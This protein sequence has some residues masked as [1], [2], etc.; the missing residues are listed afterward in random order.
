MASQPKPRLAS[1]IDQ[2]ARGVS[3][4]AAGYAARSLL[5]LGLTMM[6]ARGL[7]PADYGAISVFLALAA[8]IA[9][10]AGAWPFVAV[11]ILAARGVRV[12]AVFRPALVLA[13]IGAVVSAAIVLPFASP[14]GLE[15]SGSL[16]RLVLY[17]AALLA[18]HGLYSVFQTEGRMQMIAFT[19]AGER[20]VTLLLVASL[21]AF[22][23]LTVAGAEAA[24]AVA[25]AVFAAAA[26]TATS[27]RLRL[28]SRGGAGASPGIRVVVRTV[29]AMAVVTTAT[30]LIAW[31]DIVLL[32]A[33][34]T[35]R[36]TGLY[37]LAY[38]IFTVVIQVGAL[39]IVAALP[40]H[41]RRAASGELDI[42]EALPRGKLLA[43][44]RAWGAAVAIA[45]VVGAV[46]LTTVFGEG[47]AESLGP[48]VVL[49]SSACF[50]AP[51]FARVPLLIASGQTTSLA[52]VTVAA[53]IVN[54]ALD[55]ALIPL[56]GIWGP[57]FATAAVNA[58]SA[59]AVVWLMSGA[60]HVAA[61]ALAA[62]PTALA[63]GLLAL[64]PGEPA[65]LGLVAVVAAAVGLRELWASRPRR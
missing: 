4:L 31:I 29:G 3:W 60:R 39:W 11:P 10:L 43:A 1:L 27:R 50:L 56:V 21:V 28:L 5:S 6:L 17:A 12:G 49:L 36:E 40:G 64:D 9:Y 45:T 61:T 18:L 58:G 63:I 32:A 19:Q 13:G 2:P 34:R 35:A 26:L 41:A 46:T 51:Y 30:Y 47:F 65:L 25:G 33:L 57:A 42:D 22:G 38:Q 8:G 54:V 52:V 23:A 59:L 48:L 53:V 55:L 7:G 15:G 44:T 24:L 16:A 37:A 20:L 62:A 14:L